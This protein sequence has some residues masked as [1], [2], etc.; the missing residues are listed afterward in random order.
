M[1][2][3]LFPQAIVLISVPVICQLFFVFTL[4][5]L[6]AQSESETARETRSREIIAGADHLTKL[7]EEFGYSLYFYYSSKT[8]ERRDLLTSTCKAMYDEIDHLRPLVAE[9]PDEKATL[10]QVTKQVD[11]IRQFGDVIV[12]G[13]DSGVNY[14]EMH[15]ALQARMRIL[16][17]SNNMLK[18]LRRLTQMEHASADQAKSQWP[19]TRKLIWNLLILGVVLNISIALFLARLF[20][21][22]TSTRLN[23]LVEN[24]KRLIVGEPLKPAIAGRDEIA[25]L[26][27]V[28]HE[29]AAALAEARRKE[30]AIIDDASDAI[31][32]INA[33]FDFVSA[34][35]A[36][37]QIFGFAPTQLLGKNLSA[38]VAQE[39]WQLVLASL[40]DSRENGKSISFDCH[41]LRADENHADIQWSVH[42][43]EKESCF[44]CVARDISE[45]KRLEAMKQE[46]VSMV[47]HDLR[48]PLMSVQADIELLSHAS[49]QSSEN[50]AESLSS[51][52]RNIKY[53]IS[54]INSLLDLERM[55]ADKLEVHLAL[56][57]LQT[58]FDQA[59]DAV[60]PL[61][62]KKQIKLACPPTEAIVMADQARLGQVLI[63]LVSNA[64]KF[65]EENT[66]VKIQVKELVDEIEIRVVDQGRG[67]PAEKLESIFG[68]FE[69]VEED[70]TKIQGGAG[71]GLAICRKI[72]EEHH[73]RI[74]VD[75]KQDRGSE[76]WIR[77]PV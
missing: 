42:W 44:F 21:S 12:K 38:L 41:V 54:L 8:L 70:D 34:N 67:I 76:F 25:E 74:G 16:S 43:S 9:R 35:P 49:P 17:I 77:L 1:N 33:N 20:Y 7:F 29:M 18:L 10:E 72:I 27:G 28:F 66:C 50:N 75:S 47:S 5:A 51:A 32:A 56:V 39:D 24:T 36:A 23:N 69:Q 37:K 71:L 65:S 22:G 52:G 58:V 31:C 15:S 19:E 62:Q 40:K 68:R 14:D 61:A 59:L 26:D 30:R 63:N 3:K 45:R 57:R 46:F 73:G 64:L 11:T 4:A 60:L 13:V 53:V 6:L 48:T 55:A 2:L